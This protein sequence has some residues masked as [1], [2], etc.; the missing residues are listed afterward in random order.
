MKASKNG[1]V[2]ACFKK[3]EGKTWEA[4]APDA[5]C[6]A[7]GEKSGVATGENGIPARE[8]AGGACGSDGKAITRVFLVLVELE[9]LLR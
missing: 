2:E 7:T 9:V 3:T 6:V 5:S 1:G 8:T 4:G